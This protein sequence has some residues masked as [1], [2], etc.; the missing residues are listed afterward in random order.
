MPIV[1]IG[2]GPA[3]LMAAEV[4]S[5]SGAKVDLYDAMPSPGRKFL[6]AGKSG[7]N[8]THSESY[9]TFITR[10]GSKQKEIAAHLQHFTPTDLLAWVKELKVE[11]FVG[12][13][14]RVFP[15]EMKASPLLR[16]WLQ[17]LQAGGVT[18]HTRYRWMGWQNHLLVFDSPNGVIKIKPDAT[19]LALGGASWPRLGSCGDWV[20]WLEQHGVEVKPFRPAN[21]GFTVNWSKHFSEK[22]HGQPIKPV[23]LSF[24]DFKQRGEFVVTRTGV[25]GSLIYTAS[26]KLRD[27]IASTGDAVLTLDLA[28]DSSREKLIRALARPRGSRSM[29]SHIQ[30][31]TGIQGAKTG[32]LY[33]FIAREDF[34]DIERLADAIK[35]LRIPLSAPAPIATAISS[36]GGIDF[37]ELD[38]NLMLRKMPG[39]FCAGEMLDWEA[40]TGGYLLTACFATGR[41]AGNGAL[42]WLGLK[43][44]R[45]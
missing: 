24:K 6:M 13:S 34:A 12:T 36:A 1:I 14:G 26:A 3:G 30:K 25:E 33:E 29:T 11:T 15:K 4:L 37:D 9:Q 31:T 45:H 22:F 42:H 16:A 18:F 21:C 17:R 5:Q 43:T 28:P 2:G 10:Y 32:L 19:I 40:P 27:E 38:A 20:S 39:V 23:V 7:L 44:A 41:S 35:A 8:L